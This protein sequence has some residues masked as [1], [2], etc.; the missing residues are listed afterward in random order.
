[1]DAPGAPPL[2][3]MPATCTGSLGHLLPDFTEIVDTVDI[4]R[5]PQ[6]CTSPD[7]KVRATLTTAPGLR[8][9]IGI[10]QIP[11]IF[12][13]SSCSQSGCTASID[14]PSLSYPNTDYPRIRVRQI[15]GRGSY[16][17]TVQRM[18]LAQL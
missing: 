2:S 11:G 5:S 14:A 18:S 8:A 3:T 6:R 13:T 16:A 4:F 1:A 12:L 10:E 17:L 7:C 9:E 15:S